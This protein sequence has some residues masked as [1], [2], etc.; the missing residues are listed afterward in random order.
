MHVRE[1]RRVAKVERRG[2]GGTDVFQ[3]KRSLKRMH[4]IEPNPI[5]Y[6]ATSI[7]RVCEGTWTQRGGNGNN[8]GDIPRYLQRV[9]ASCRV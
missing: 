9:D 1:G 8:G 4:Q 5:F 6:G 2:G 3:A 7:S